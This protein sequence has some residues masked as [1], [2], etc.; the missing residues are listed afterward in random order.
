MGK[1]ATITKNLLFCIPWGNHFVSLDHSYSAEFKLWRKIFQQLPSPIVMNP[2][3]TQKYGF[4][5]WI[6]LER[7]FFFN[8]LVYLMIFFAH[9]IKIVPDFKYGKNIEKKENREKNISS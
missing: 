2:G 9:R 5:F 8:F 7:R 3:G 6:Q 1:Y 4:G